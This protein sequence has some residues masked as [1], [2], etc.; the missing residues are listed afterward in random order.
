[1]EKYIDIDDEKLGILEGRDCIYIDTV[2]LNNA[3]M[4]SF[5]GEINGLL[6]SRICEEK[7]I[8][9]KLVFNRVIFYSACELD[10][11]LNRGHEGR[12]S[13]FF[14]IENS[15]QLAA[16]PIRGDLNRSVYKHFRVFT[17]DVVFDIFAVGFELTADF[18][19]IKKL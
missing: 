17:Y 9:F 12:H 16:L 15:E 8:P 11:F 2:A 6:A 13:C 14:V 19:K 7:P 10:T 18:D 1:M 5:E 3:D 4:L